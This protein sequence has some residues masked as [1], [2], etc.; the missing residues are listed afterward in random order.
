MSGAPLVHSFVVVVEGAGAGG[1]LVPM[2]AA[3][4]AATRIGSAPQQCM[5][6]NKGIR[7]GL[8]KNP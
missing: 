5:F 2:F 7:G 3:V 1:D 8:I 6:V 4:G